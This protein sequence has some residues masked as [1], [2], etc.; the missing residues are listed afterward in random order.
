[1]ISNF[2]DNHCKMINKILLALDRFTGKKISLVKGERKN[3]QKL[4]M[5][6]RSEAH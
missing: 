2:S 1:M 3:V 6:K 5:T 4:K